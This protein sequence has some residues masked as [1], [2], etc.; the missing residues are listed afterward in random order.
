MRT[1]R[2]TRLFL[3]F[4]CAGA[5]TGTAG[6]APWI[7][8]GDEQLRHH[9]EML[10]DAGVIR[11]PITTWPIMWGA[12][13]RDLEQAKDQSLDDATLWSLAYVRFAL[14]RAT[15]A[16]NLTAYAGGRSDAAA[17][18]DFANDQREQNEAR[19][20]ADWVG[21]H[22]AARLR[23]AWV[24]DATD[25]KD[26]RYDGSYVAGLLGNWSLSAGAI[27]RWWGPGWQSSLN[28]S[29][30]ARPV[31]SVQLQRNFSDPFETRWLS[32][33]GPW[34]LTLFAGQLESESAV[35]DAKLLG[36]R[37]AFR[38]F[39]SLELGFARNAQW[40]GEG[41]PQDL[42]SLWD[43]VVGNDNGDDDGYDP[44]VDPA[45]DPSNQLGAVDL[46]WSFPL[47]QTRSAFYLQYTGEDESNGFPS[48]GM[49]LAGI[50][51]A[52]ASRNLFHRFAL[53]YVNSMAGAHTDPRPNTAYEHSVYLSGYRYRSRP[54]GASFDND[55]RALTL[56][57]D[58]YFT[59]GDQISWR[60]IQ[61]AL[62]RD[63]EN[64]NN[65]WG[66]SVFA[67]EAVDT[68]LLQAS[69]SIVIKN[70]KISTS[71]YNVDEEIMWNDESINGTGAGL[72]V[73]YR[74]Q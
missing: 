69:Y 31:N 41:R 59:D 5:L 63:G 65:G 30:S 24:P 22:L 45:N 60:I 32:W 38:P 58:H 46:R 74:F 1:D 21:E 44:V 53:E 62:N 54:I 3:A 15:E 40:G 23:L 47:L 71:V 50:E 64:R 35:P 19:G 7:D 29:T 6:A 34:T 49:D 28:L 12:V 25:G 20:E 42:D 52:F 39:S 4:I 37:L 11:S 27:D 33:I 67:A 72:A 10:A 18:A 55:T 70:F 8:P 16:L 13:S 43:L 66:G 48:R 51:T 61:V 9:I 36:A 57:G 17:I 14:N 2:I 68:L 26:Y 56:M 73:E